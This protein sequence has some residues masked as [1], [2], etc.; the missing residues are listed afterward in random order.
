MKSLIKKIRAVH[1]PWYLRNKYTLTFFLLFAWVLLFDGFDLVTVTK[2]RLQINQKEKEIEQL[3]R[4]IERDKQ[5]FH[6]LTSDPE[7]LEKFA[8]EEYLMKR[9]NEDIYVI[10][11]ADK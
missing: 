9:E 4:W 2:M 3:D 6:E 1:I 11:P 10:V 5:Y 8:R 7:Q